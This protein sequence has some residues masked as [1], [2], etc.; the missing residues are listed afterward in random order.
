MIF[1]VRFNPAAESIEIIQRLAFQVR[2]GDDSSER[3]IES[4]VIHTASGT[5][6]RAL[7]MVKS[8]VAD[9]QDVRAT[10][11]PDV[12]TPNDATPLSRLR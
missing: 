3:A 5:S 7:R 10:R 8:C 9:L 11:V 12:T 1:P 2:F 4:S 6:L